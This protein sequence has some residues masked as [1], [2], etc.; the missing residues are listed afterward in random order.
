MARMTLHFDSP[1]QGDCMMLARRLRG[2]VADSARDDL[3][4]HQHDGGGQVYMYPRV[5]YR[6][7][8]DGV[9]VLLGIEEGVDSLFGLAE[10]LNGETLCLG[11]D[12]YFVQ[13]V[14]CDEYI[15][16][17]GATDDPVFYN[18]ASP[19]L[20]FNHRNHIRYKR[21]DSAGRMKLL[22]SILVANCLSMAKSLGVFVA[23]KIDVTEC[24]LQEK[25]V[26]FKDI[27]M[28]AFEGGVAINFAVP[29]GLGI[30]KSPSRGFGTLELLSCKKR[31]NQ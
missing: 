12:R 31:I 24:L 22:K 1:L 18:F 11:E 17:F 28:L 13:S 5:Q 9:G 29:A 6:V 3:L 23:E 27:D 8:D 25:P 21:A 14:E 30:G 10:R 26:R 20:A 2:A 4:L 19:W 7:A 15:A 16:E